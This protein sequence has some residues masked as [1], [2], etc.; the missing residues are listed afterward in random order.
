MLKVERH[1]YEE[2]FLLYV[3]NELNAEQRL[4]VEN[5]IAQNEDLRSEFE[6]LQQAVLSLDD[7]HFNQKDTLLKKETGI[8]INN[9]ETYF[10]LSVDNELNNT[11]KASVEK[12]VL[13][14]PKL[15]DEFTL[16]HKTKLKPEAIIFNNKEALLRKERR[17]V[18]MLWM[19]MSVAAAVIGIVAFSWFASNDDNNLKTAPLA[20]N[21][22]T[23]DR[24]EE[25]KIQKNNEQTVT[26]NIVDPLHSKAAVLKV[27]NKS[28]PKTT[29]FVEPKSQSHKQDQIEYLVHQKNENI[30]QPLVLDNNITVAT[31]KNE[32]SIIPLPNTIGVVGS[33]NKLNTSST[34]AASNQLTPELPSIAS[35]AMYKEVINTDEEDK[36]VYIGN[37]QINKNKIKSLFKKASGIFGKKR[38]KDPTE[39]SVQV[40][41]FE[42]RTT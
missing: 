6:M 4:A 36:S 41:G 12:F 15:Q 34:V 22:P 38:E 18:S 42:I 20:I 7:I 27:K 21:N 2:Y 14:H 16:L 39:K 30:P 35:Q 25:N 8:S 5:F 10:L 11:E 40:A 28:N 37:L 13:Q 3:D 29:K 17:V 1:N 24:K 32:T 33:N 31:N 19:R 26:Q 9:Y 23:V